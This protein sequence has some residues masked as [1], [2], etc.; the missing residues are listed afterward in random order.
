MQFTLCTL[1]GTNPLFFSAHC[2]QK[3]ESDPEE[4]LSERK[5]SEIM[6]AGKQYACPM[7]PENQH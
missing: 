4:F 1:F 5:P 3:F 2:V 7:H 6:P